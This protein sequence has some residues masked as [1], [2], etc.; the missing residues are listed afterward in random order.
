[1]KQKK[2]EINLDYDGCKGGLNN[3]DKAASTYTCQGT[4]VRGPVA[5]FQNVLDISA[6]QYF[7]V[8]DRIQPH[9]E[10]KSILQKT[11]FVEELGMILGK[12]QMKQ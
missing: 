9:K 6:L 2:P 12:S 10:P 8:L 3:L 7:N 5:Q 4:T 11:M 1:M